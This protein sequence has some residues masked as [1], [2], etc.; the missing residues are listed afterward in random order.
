M[1]DADGTDS[2]FLFETD[3]VWDVDWIPG[4]GATSVRPATWGQIKSSLK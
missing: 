1:V 3:V 2:V 4:S